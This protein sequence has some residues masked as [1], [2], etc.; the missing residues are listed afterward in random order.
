MKCVLNGKKVELQSKM[1]IL[2]AARENG[3]SI[4]SLCDFHRL[5][6]FSGCRLCLVEI[7]GRRGFVPSCSTFVEEEMIIKTDSPQLKRLR[8][9]ILELILSEHPSSCLICSEKKHCDD[10]K[11]TIRK[12]G[13]T[14]GCVLCPNNGRCELQDVVGTLEVDKIEFP[15]VYRNIEIRKDDPFFDRNYN[16]CILCGRCV[17][18]CHEVRGASAISFVHR[19]SEE[20]IGTVFDKPLLDSGCQFCGACVD[21]CPTGALTERAIKY[22]TLPGESKRTICPLCGI[23]C[24]LDVEVRDGRIISSRP[25]TDST[26]NKGQGCVKGRFII[27]DAVHSS[28]RIARPMIRKG[29]ELE[30][31]GWDEALDFVAGKLKSFKGK[32]I[33]LVD[34]P[35]LSIEDIYTGRK[36]AQD[37]LKTQN[38]ASS[39]DSARHSIHSCLVDQPDFSNPLNFKIE[40]IAQADT[41]VLIGSDLTATHPIV[42]LE[43]L[44]AV[45]NGGNLIVISPMEYLL[46]R[47][48]SNWL[49]CK[50]GTEMYVI[51]YLA[52]ILSEEDEF[53]N[54]AEKEGGN[55]FFESL[56]ALSLSEIQSLT[57][58]EESELRKAS[59][60]LTGGKLTAFLVGSEF[61]RGQQGNEDVQ[62]LQNLAMMTS[63]RIF[64][65]GLENN[66][67]GLFELNRAVQKKN[68][69]LFSLFQFMAAG[70]IKALYLTGSFPWPKKTK[71]DFTVFQGN[72]NC[73][74]V[75]KADAVLP[76][77]TF[78]ETK[79]TCVNIEGRVQFFDAVI[80]PVA[81]SK[82]DWWILSQIAQRMNAEG[83]AFRSVSD[84][85]KEIKKNV[86]GFKEISWKDLE[87]GK[88]VF[89]KDNGKKGAAFVPVE[90]PPSIPAPTKKYPL[91]MLNGDNLD[92]YRNLMLSDDAQGLERLRNPRWILI[93]SEDAAKAGVKN[94]ETIEI[95]SEWGGFSGQVKVTSRIFPG[96]L[97]ASFAWH[98]DP[99]VFAAGLSSG[100]SEGIEF[101]RVLPVK[102]KRGK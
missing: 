66:Q 8:R 44:Q 69:N 87:S 89:V 57:G 96:I 65:L 88:E 48:A 28:K 60:C 62:F 21:V 12:V 67:R 34:S 94:G 38:V 35:H 79:G 59:L 5:S 84:I 74:A 54:P 41:V 101:T 45:R 55:L 61:A 47:H 76:A 30:E 6:P 100:G 99:N 85:A 2:E 58:I 33:A 72:Y 86:A 36:F 97:R 22:E 16:L 70:R 77:A 25:S 23:G 4:P 83:F 32:E 53:F 81:E 78:A 98:E 14:T 7:E 1:T 73:E 29:R 18:M 56:H 95:L 20:V 37:V 92:V 13:E 19:G 50:P 63:G 82:P 15:A 40:D 39:P 71:I 42:W 26:V 3:I 24:T 9:Q 52:K 27:K 90:F 46:S 75:Q 68:M 49:R 80:E 10:K 64:P 93:N 102:I 43:A 11:T 91:L 31:V 51:G 17:R